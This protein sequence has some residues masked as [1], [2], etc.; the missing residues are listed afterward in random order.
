MK[1]K[2]PSVWSVEVIMAHPLP[3][4]AWYFDPGHEDEARVLFDALAANRGV[5]QNDDRAW[6]IGVNL[7][8]WEQ[9]PSYDEA[10]GMII[11]Q[12]GW[13]ES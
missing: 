11:A 1:Y 8:A 6:S 2:S 9:H 13:S 7:V 5:I 12:Q 10:V 3:R 4:I